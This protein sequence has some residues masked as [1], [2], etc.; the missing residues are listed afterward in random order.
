MSPLELD[1]SGRVAGAPC[2]WG[3]NETP[4]W[5][6]Q[7]DAGRVLR[8]M[9]EIGLS[10]TEFGPD[11]FLPDD[12]AA[13]ADLLARSDLRAVGAFVPAVL[14]Q[15]GH[16]PGPDVRRAVQGLVAAQASTLVLAAATGVDGYDSR[17]DLDAEGW[18]TLLANVDRMAA[19]AGQA[20]LT[21]CLHPHVG[22]MVETR[23]DVLRLLDGAQIPICL[24][25]GHLLVGGTD[26]VEIAQQA[27]DRVAHVHL[28]DVDADLARQARSGA[29]TYTAAVGAGMYKPLGSG[30]VDVAALV[31]AL[32]RVGY[33]GWYVLEQDALLVEEPPEGGGPIDDARVSLAF[34][35][36][37]TA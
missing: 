37:L 31:S 7:L 14:H 8:E 30:D 33:R 25:T 24:D 20:G 35:N 12:P 21:A 32:E 2:S 29:M 23:E 22:T 36:A 17:P 16:D 9:R 34:L 18:R 6:Y 15:P 13:K 5:G 11:G 4:G 28:K 3:V 26:P 27:G 10:A 1:L 19:V